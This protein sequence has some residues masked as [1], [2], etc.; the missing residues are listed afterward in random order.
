MR[1]NKGQLKVRASAPTLP[2]ERTDTP[3]NPSESYN[4]EH[5][6]AVQREWLHQF[7]RPLKRVSDLTLTEIRTIEA[8][9]RKELYP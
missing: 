6:A 4:W 7:R 1:K 5:M 8:R 3:G 9:V 2:I